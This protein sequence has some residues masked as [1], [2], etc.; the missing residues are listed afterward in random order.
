MLFITFVFNFVYVC[1]CIRFGN[2]QIKISLIVCLLLAGFGDSFGRQLELVG[3]SSS[4]R[5]CLLLL[6]MD[7][8]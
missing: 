2:L 1:L 8:A 6:Y 4:F 7:K 5:A 3:L